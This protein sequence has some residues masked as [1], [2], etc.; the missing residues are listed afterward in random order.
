MARD[1][2]SAAR[3][4]RQ[5]LALGISL[6][7]LSAG[8]T[9]AQQASP[10]SDAQ[11]DSGTI[12]LD[13]ITITGSAGAATGTIGQP[14]PAY[15][16]GQ[17][18]TQAGVGMLGYRDVQRAPF[19]LTRYTDKTIR[20]QQARSVADITVNDP[21][22]RQDAPAFSERDSFFIRGFSVTNLDTL[23]DGLPYIANPRKSHLEGIEQVDVL[24]GPTAFALGGTGRVGGT[25]NLVPK[26]AG[27]E[28]LT[29]LTTTYLSDSQLW[30]HLDVGRRF[31]TSG[32]WGVRGNLSYRSGDT[33][34]EHNSNEIGV[35]TLGV[36]YRG[37]NLRASLDFNHTTQNID[38]PTSLFNAALPG[39]DIPDAPN[40]DINAA[41]PF[42]YHDS[43]YNMIAGR[44]EY[45]IQPNTTIYAA[46]G[47]SRYREDFLSTN[48]TITGSNGDA[49]NSFGYNPQEIEGVSGEIGLRSEFRTG[50][51][52]HQFSVALTRSVN[53]N[54][55]GENFHPGRLGFPEYPINIYDPVYLA[56]RPDL[57][58]LPQSHE[59]VPFAELRT[60][61]IA[62]AD[63]MS[64]MEDRIQVT[65]GGRYTDIR[66]RGFNTRPGTVIGEQNYLYEKSKFTPAIAVSA[67]VADGVTVYANYVEALTEGPTAPGTALNAGEIFAPVVNKQKEIGVKYDMGSTALSASLFEIRQP[68]GITDPASNVFSVS[69][70]QVNRGLELSVFGEPAQGVRVMGG[71][72][73]MDAE[74]RRTQDGAFDGNDVTGVP[75][76]AISFYGEYDTPWLNDLTLTGRV[77][78]SGSTYYDQANTQKISDWT[79]VD[80]GARYTMQRVDGNPIEFRA[81]IH[82]LLDEN[83]WASSA[84]GFLAPGA[85]RSF[86][87]SAAMAF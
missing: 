23:F 31:G 11:G 81:N 7:A 53:K 17:V 56:D 3:S 85:P 41:N 9:A 65:L 15:A 49:T 80:V 25:I 67:M 29:R 42:E 52:G 71:I 46:A 75:D 86:A 32:E 47:A 76:T 5:R 16:G 36:D 40:G 6:L 79:R 30:A 37:E 38:A 84:R 1:E 20:D 83:Y 51:V 27:D 60:T 45:D 57:T 63:T 19:R 72:T 22:V 48:Y 33:P 78:Y 61:T 50:N 2:T 8:A 66:S 68:N 14:S 74:L 10:V 82:N 58:G 44:I 28:P 18:A 35:A 34:L 62:I 59:L 69:G 39:I 55:R 21:S 54:N 77:V 13:R 64:F 87:L 70:L 12:L 43:S 24:L 26:R 4:G 73:L